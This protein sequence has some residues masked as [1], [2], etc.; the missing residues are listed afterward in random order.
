MAYKIMVLVKAALVSLVEV[1]ALPRQG[2]NMAAVVV[3]LLAHKAAGQ[4]VQVL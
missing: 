2:V 3:A 4:V 1:V